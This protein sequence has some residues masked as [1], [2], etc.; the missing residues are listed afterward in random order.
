MR[1][2]LGIRRRRLDSVEN[3]AK[4]ENSAS[5]AHLCTKTER[6]SARKF[7]RW[8]TGALK[9]RQTSRWGVCL[10]LACFACTQSE[11]SHSKAQK[12]PTEMGFQ[13]WGGSQECQIEKVC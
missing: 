9:K 1:S 4:S 3:G 6:I 5:H 8:R 7:H 13:F 12:S 11:I 2:D 10:R